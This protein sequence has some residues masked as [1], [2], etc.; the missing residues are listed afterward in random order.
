MVELH[1]AYGT[2]DEG[3]GLVWATRRERLGLE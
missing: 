3:Q 1:L 2:F